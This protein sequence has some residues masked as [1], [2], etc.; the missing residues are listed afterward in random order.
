MKTEINK[1]I[2]L[3]IFLGML[4]WLGGIMLTPVMA[5]SESSLLRKLATFGYF[6]YHP[7][8]HQLPGRS[9]LLDGFSLAVCIRCFSFYLSGLLTIACFL[10]N[11]RIKMWPV[12]LYLVLSLPVLLDFVLEKILLYGDIPI[13]RIITGFLLGVA[14]FQLLLVSLFSIKLPVIERVE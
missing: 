9:F 14:V 12:S 10:F 2:V 8:C 1:K 13:I 6:F 11:N 7:V 4:L 5:A 3:F